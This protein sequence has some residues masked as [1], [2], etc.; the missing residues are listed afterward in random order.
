MEGKTLSDYKLIKKLG[1]SD[2]CFI[3]EHRFTKKHFAIKIIPPEFYHLPGFKDRFEKEIV[4]LATLDHP[5]IVKVHNVSFAEERYFLVSDC[6]LD[7][8]VTSTN[9]L[10]YVSAKKRRMNEEELFNILLDVAGA[11]DF[12]H[13][14]EK[15]VI[16]HGCLKL[17]SVLIGKENKA[18]VTD[19][20]LSRI[21]GE[22][23]I[24]KN[25]FKTLASNISNASLTFS[26]L[27]NFAFLAPEQKAMQPAT[28]LSDV[29]AFGVMAYFLIAKHFPEGILEPVSELAPEYRYNW[30][31]LFKGCLAFQEE[32]RRKELVPLLE[33]I[34]SAILD[35]K[36]ETTFINAF[37]RVI[38]ENVREEAKVTLPQPVLI[39]ELA[40]VGAIARESQIHQMLNREPIVTAYHPE[41]RETKEIKPILTPMV[42][43]PSGQYF[44]GN[45]Q[46]N[47]D[48]SPK[49]QVF[50]NTFSIDT[51]PV[52]NEQFIL[53][54]E[55]MGGEKD[56]NYHDLIRLKDSR[57]NRAAGKLSIEPGY[58]KHPV[59][60]VTWYGASGYAK[61]IGKRLPTE[62]E[63]EIAASGNSSSLFPTGDS[64]EK[65]QANFFSSDTMA[66]KSYPPN[67]YGLYD[68]VGNV[69][70]WCQDWYSYNYYET[71]AIEPNNPK[72]PQQGVYRV[73]RG[74]CWKSLK[75]DLRCSHRHRNN[76]GTV[77]GTYGFRCASDN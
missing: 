56:Q 6:I 29:F 54:L 37:P 17:N 59:V 48:E 16:V 42:V 33:E 62:A 69:Y 26:V 60:G 73:L 76:P 12:I 68:M 46:G 18:F 52:T 65:N 50:L 64:I 51:H 13:A 21:F 27:Q 43:I 49:H 30:D 71:S 20:G 74:G 22:E 10:Q 66:V 72:G 75:E 36:K 53:F 2:T 39:P 1:S 14:K 28:A 35:G 34:K 58:D 61:W 3:A 7:E 5:Q 41:C 45:N 9:L 32:K 55:Y 70:E 38:Q 31:L 77:N 63:W 47:R 15:G 67:S 19:V 4:T 57:I 8:S 25:A 23:L 24:I 11:L 44:R 40:E